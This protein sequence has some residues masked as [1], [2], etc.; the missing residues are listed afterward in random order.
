MSDEGHLGQGRARQTSSSLHQHIRTIYF[1]H[2]TMPPLNCSRILAYPRE[3]ANF[4]GESSIASPAVIDSYDNLP[5]SESNDC[6]L[7]SRAH[8]CRLEEIIRFE[9]SSLKGPTAP[10][11]ES[12]CAAKRPEESS[13]C[14]INSESESFVC[15]LDGLID[16]MVLNSL[17]LLLPAID[18]RRNFS[19][20]MF[21]ASSI[22][23]G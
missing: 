17:S 6:V 4:S 22:D 23:L 21:F 16:L 3:S 14:T 2:S 9:D 20:L 8:F 10:L 7:V 12:H 15:Q 18:D 5:S 13:S 19:S 1:L 11:E